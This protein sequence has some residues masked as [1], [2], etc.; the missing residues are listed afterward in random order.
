MRLGVAHVISIVAKASAC[1]RV[2]ILCEFLEK[3]NVIATSISY[4]IA[5][6]IDIN[7][8]LCLTNCKRRGCS[9]V[10]NIEMDQICLENSIFGNDMS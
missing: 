7:R 1:K 8:C 5:I 4:I 6:A 3:V 10:V 9:R 2:M